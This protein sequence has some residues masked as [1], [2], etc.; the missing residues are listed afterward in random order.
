M[1]TDLCAN[2]VETDTQRNF[3]NG[4]EHVAN[5]TLTAPDV[6]KIFAVTPRAIE[7]EFVK[8]RSASEDE[9]LAKERVVGELD[10]EPGKYKVLFDVFRSCPRN[11]STPMC[12]V[13]GRDHRSCSIRMLG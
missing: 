5:S 13:G 7:P 4:I 10:D 9:I 12:D 11:L 1:P 2:I 3:A 6:I 8:T